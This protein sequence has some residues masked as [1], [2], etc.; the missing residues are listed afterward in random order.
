MARQYRTDPK[1]RILHKG[2]T[3]LESKRLYRYTYTDTSG[4]RV[5]KYSKDLAELRKEETKI[6]KD[7]ADGLDTYAMGMAT[8]NYVF[9]RYIDLKTEL[10]STTLW[11]YTNTYDTYVRNG[12]GKK[13]IAKIKY[14][15]VLA[16]YNSLLESGLSISVVDNVNSVVHPTFTMAVRDEVIRKNPS[17]NVLAE[18]KRKCR[19]K[20]NKRKA[21]T[22]D[23]QRAFLQCLD[24]P[25]FSRWKSILVTLFGTG[26]RIGELVALRWD[27]VDFENRRICVRN[28]ITYCPRTDNDLK[29]EY[30]ISTPKTKDGI[31]TI[32][33]LDEVYDALVEEK[34]Y[35]DSS[36]NHCLTE[37]DGFSGF[38]FFNRF[39]EVHNQGT[40]NRAIKRVLTK[41]NYKEEVDAAKEHRKPLLI[42]NFSCH[43]ARHTFCTRLCENDVNLKVIQTVMG[44]KD[45][46]TTMDIY[47]EV[48]EQKK[49]EAF[50]N[51]RGKSV[52]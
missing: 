37:L 3:Y 13:K 30:R 35:Q 1:N 46:Q 27:D 22:I 14:S 41:Y 23:E 45:I 34:E 31:R 10:K 11:N 52:F 49:A 15:D 2:E 47:A 43:V 28:N 42:P 25:E 39:K 5:S 36:G 24:D 18:V 19:N 9:D 7:V 44:H 38:V 4:K 32:P 26:C 16:F 8:L 48:S 51:L 21:L 6:R 29:C 12:F 17:D 33:M 50:E 40:V 20:G